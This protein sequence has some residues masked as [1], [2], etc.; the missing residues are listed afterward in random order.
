[1]IWSGGTCAVTGV[2]TQAKEHG[3]LAQQ[4]V[5]HGAVRIVANV[6]VLAYR[7]VLVSEWPLFFRMAL[8]A[9][10]IDRWFLSNCPWSGRGD[11]GTPHTPSCLRQSD[12]ATAWRSW[13]RCWGD[14]DSML[15]DRP[16]TLEFG[17]DVRYPYG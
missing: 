11:H 9:R 12:D 15:L 1:M 13:R 7:R 2:A 8:I 6:A 5:G 3:G 4:V 10:Q 17:K 14:S 16:P